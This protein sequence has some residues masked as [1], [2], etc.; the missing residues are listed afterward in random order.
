MLS[1]GS[2]FF[3]LTTE[4]VRFVVILGITIIITIGSVFAGDSPRATIKPAAFDFGWLPQK[5]KV[6]YVFYIHNEGENPLT[7]T[8]IKPGCSCTSISKIEKPI[9]PGDSTGVIVTFKSG[10]YLNKVEKTTKIYTD[11]PDTEILEF[12]LT[13]NVFKRGESSGDIAVSPHELT[14]N[15]GEDKLPSEEGKLEIVNNGSDTVITSVSHLP[16]EIVDKPQLPSAI[17][18]TVKTDLSLHFIKPS[19]SNDLE[20]LFIQFKFNGNDETLISVPIEVEL[21]N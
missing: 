21:K 1:F 7:V 15:Y 12:T 8:K 6:S 20:G 11:D 10:R 9:P 3:K 14:V 13:A 17:A 16:E 4:S 19:E 2:S 18:P 5:A